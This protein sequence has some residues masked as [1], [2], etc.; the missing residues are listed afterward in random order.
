MFFEKSN[1]QIKENLFTYKKKKKKKISK[2]DFDKSLLVLITYF[3][4]I[5]RDFQRRKEFILHDLDLK[6]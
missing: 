1:Q 5:P 4:G 2:K 6:I 3:S